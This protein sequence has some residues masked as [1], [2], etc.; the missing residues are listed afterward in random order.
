MS[1]NELRLLKLIQT[2]FQAADQDRAGFL[3]F[4][5]FREVIERLNIDLTVDD[6]LDMCERMKN[7]YGHI[8]YQAVRGH[9]HLRPSRREISDN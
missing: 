4:T 8:T 7:D 2:A 6:F 1:D 9:A 3:N 5:R